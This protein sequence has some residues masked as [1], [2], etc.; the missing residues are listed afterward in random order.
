MPGSQEPAFRIVDA[1]EL[2]EGTWDAGAISDGCNAMGLRPEPI[3]YLW[4]FERP[5]SL[6][7]HLISHGWVQLGPVFLLVSAD[8][9]LQDDLISNAAALDKRLSRTRYDAGRHSCPALSNFEVYSSYRG[10][11]INALW[12]AD[13]IWQTAF[14]SVISRCGYVL[15][16]LTTDENPSGLAYELS[17]VFAHVAAHRIVLFAD[18]CRADLD[19]IL[20]L[21]GRL[22]RESGAK[23]PTPPLITYNS[24][25]L[26]YLAKATWAQWTGRP[27]IPLASKATR[28]A[29]WC[30]RG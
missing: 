21:L 8:A 14:E 9:P 25:S 22:W 4:V 7:H 12:C 17:Y 28:L 24:A 5:D 27:T 16:D 19:L 1:S 3:L 6:S 15:A 20:P 2:P 29:G 26:G 23:G 13:R 10:Y 30:G 18:L 11:P